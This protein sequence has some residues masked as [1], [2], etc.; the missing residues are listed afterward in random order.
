MLD[1]LF[2]T[3]VARCL[4]SHAFYHMLACHKAAKG[5]PA[6]ATVAIKT[7]SNSSICCCTHL[8][9]IW[10][11]KPGGAGLCLC[12]RHAQA[13]PDQAENRSSSAVH[14]PGTETQSKQHKLA[15][16]KCCNIWWARSTP[17][18]VAL[19]F[20]LWSRSTCSIALHE[21][22]NPRSCLT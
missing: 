15:F 9:I 6:M 2:D 1:T 13:R 20:Q 11:S 19:R 5:R 14:G 10:L 22:T 4:W 3:G 16:Q 12:S 17:A 18:L 8:P 21:M 7:C